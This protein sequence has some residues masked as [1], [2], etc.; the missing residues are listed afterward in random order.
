MSPTKTSRDGSGPF[1]I[2]SVDKSCLRFSDLVHGEARSRSP[3]ILRQAGN[4]IRETSLVLV[5]FSVCVDANVQ[6]I[7]FPEDK[8]PSF[9]IYNSVMVSLVHSPYAECFFG[10]RAE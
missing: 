1:V 3:V 7:G 4:S 9:P 5:V 10:T 2:S 6:V 8:R